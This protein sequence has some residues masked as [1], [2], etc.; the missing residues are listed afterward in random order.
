MPEFDYAVI[1][2]AWNE[3]EF[4][5]LC[6]ASV[7]SAMNGIDY[8]GQLIVVDN[9]S[10]DNTAELASNAGAQVVF[11]PI[12]QISRTRN[13]GAAAADASIYIFVDADSQISAAL[14]RM[15]IEAIEQNDM[16]GGGANITADRSVRQ[17]ARM[18]FKCWNWIS[19][20]FKL[21]AGC[22][23]YCRADA[24][25]A[26]G[27]FTLKRYAGEELDLSRALRRWGRSRGLK[28]HII[29]EHTIETSLRKMD[30]YTPGQLMRQVFI[31][32]LPGALNSKRFMSSWYDESIQ[33]SRKDD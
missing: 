1:I 23:V 14:L 27:G 21:A 13:A 17:P 11:E 9:N 22:F 12:N 5:P 10:T 25:E 29:T 15:A 32:M 31:A 20:R 19:R 28:F 24:F 7:Q 6:I 18:G 4:I 33:R 8:S 3:A 2:P 26:V 16:V 30:W